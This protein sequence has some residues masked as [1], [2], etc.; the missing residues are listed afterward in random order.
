MLPSGPTCTCCIIAI[1]VRCVIENVVACT[2]A[3]GGCLSPQLA[4][5]GSAAADNNA[6]KSTLAI[7][8][9]PG[10]HQGI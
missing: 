5:A 4:L 8:M 9:P 10:K 3:R 1:G 7:H 6:L 2:S